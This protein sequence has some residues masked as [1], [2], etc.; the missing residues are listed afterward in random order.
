MQS[1]KLCRDFYDPINAHKKLEN[2]NRELYEA[3]CDNETTKV[4]EIIENDNSWVNVPDGWGEYPIHFAMRKAN[5]D[6]IDYL[7]EKGSIIPP[8]LMT[9]AI[10]S[11]KIEMIEYVMKKFNLPLVDLH[12]FLTYNNYERFKFIE[13]RGSLD[14]TEA[15]VTN[16]HGDRINLIDSM[17]TPFF[18]EG[19]KYDEKVFHYLVEEKNMSPSSDRVVN[20]FYEKLNNRPPIQRQTGTTPGVTRNK[21]FISYE[22][23]MNAENE[24]DD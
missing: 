11:K 24:I 19:F 6:L 9:F 17:L 20:A 8:D 14:V 1:I 4:K 21:N 3:L 16:G 5:K 2:A 23:F 7:V 15:S 12:L 22:E 18:Q 10:Y 13:T